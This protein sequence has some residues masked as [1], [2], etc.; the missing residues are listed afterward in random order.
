MFNSKI[1]GYIPATMTYVQREESEVSDYW[2]DD[3]FSDEP[4]TKRKVRETF[5]V[6]KANPKTRKTATDWAEAS[7]RSSSKK[8][9]FT[10]IVND[11][12]SEVEVVSLDI[13]G[14]GGRAWKVL[15]HDK[16]YVDLREDV[17]LDCLRN[18]TGVRNGKLQ[19]PFQWC[20]VGTQM[21]LVRVGSKLYEAVVEAG[22]RKVS[23]RVNKNKLVVGGIYYDKRGLRSVYLGQVDTEQVVD[24]SKGPQEIPPY[25]SVCK[26]R[27]MQLWCDLQNYAKTLKAVL[28]PERG[29]NQCPWLYWCFKTAKERAFIGMEGQE[30]VPANIFDTLHKIGLDIAEHHINQELGYQR[31]P[32]LAVK[33]NIRLR[34]LA[35]YVE[36]CYLRPTGEARPD[37]PELAPLE[38]KIRKELE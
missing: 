5:V 2:E 19:G 30:K 10:D 8:A 17:L 16:Y 24:L 3:I 1:I 12:I 25:F 13:R 31:V 11:P 9:T 18:G 28:E 37:I 36:Y 7:W 21:K 27:N 38:A 4:A 14:K 20:G 33:E 15:L 29:K 34:K 32:N 6:D 35:A 22:K 26:V 23:K